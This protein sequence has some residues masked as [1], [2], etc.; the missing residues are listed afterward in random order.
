MPRFT[1]VR[2]L[3]RE[4]DFLAH[5]ERLGI[6]LPFATDTTGGALAQP[7][8]T[9]SG[10]APN[11]FAILP[12][13]GWDGTED[14]RPTDLVRRRWRRFGDSGAGLVWGGEA[15]AVRADGRA[16]PRQLVIGD[17]SSPNCERASRR[18]CRRP[19]CSSRTR[20]AGR[21]RRHAAASIAYA[22]PFLDA[23]VGVGRRAVVLTDAELDDLVGDFVDVPR[24]SRTLPASTSSTSSTATATC[25]TSS[26]ARATRAGPL[27]RTTSPAGL[28]FLTDVVAGIRARAPA[29]DIGVRLSAFDLAPRPVIR[30]RACRTTIRRTTIPTRSAVTAR[31]AESRSH[32]AARVARRAAP[33]SAS[34]S[35]AS[36]PGARTTARTCS[37]LRT[38]RRPTAIDPPQRPARRRR[39]A[40]RRHRRAA[41]RPSRT[42]SSSAAATR[43]S[44][45]GCRNVALRRRGDGRASTASA[46]AG[47]RCRTRTCRA[48]C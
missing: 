23:R 22:H 27:R 5:L 29:L 35:S 48:T 28:R 2:T 41:P 30:G 14:G 20:V 15:V 45:S 3:R 31:G 1:Q 11:R 37:V 25:C 32:R 16:N 24:S 43:I 8:D 42:S 36:P 17:A 34:G 4:E 26:S 39:A 7:L 12:M 13:E 38:S 40:A 46:S 21:A 10:T 9:S 18:R 47:S 33:A 19:A 6:E 44:R